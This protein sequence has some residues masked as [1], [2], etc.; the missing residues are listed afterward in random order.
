MNEE[1]AKFKYEKQLP[2][3]EGKKKLLKKPLTTN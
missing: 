3:E 1:A 2:P